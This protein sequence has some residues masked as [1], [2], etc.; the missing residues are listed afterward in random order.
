MAHTTTTGAAETEAS[1]EVMQLVRANPALNRWVLRLRDN[2]LSW[3]DV[4]TA[5]AEKKG[6]MRS[7]AVRVSP[8]HATQAQRVAILARHAND[9]C[10]EIAAAG[11]LDAFDQRRPACFEE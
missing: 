10:V 9:L 5:I 11:V 6:R 8:F 3:R 2:G 4:K 1:H 7:T